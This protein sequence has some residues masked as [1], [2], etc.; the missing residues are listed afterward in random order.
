MFHN[1]RL[2][3]NRQQC[4]FAI[5]KIF[6]ALAD[7]ASK[8]FSSQRRNLNEVGFTSQTTYCKPCRDLLAVSFFMGGQLCNTEGIRYKRNIAHCL[9][10][11]VIPFL[12]R[13][14]APNNNDCRTNT[15]TMRGQRTRVTYYPGPRL[16]AASSS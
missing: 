10:F 5:R 12:Q 13:T 15:R 4:V 14:M 11:D 3:N 9:S 16:I 8:M 1:P 7:D 6:K 2:H